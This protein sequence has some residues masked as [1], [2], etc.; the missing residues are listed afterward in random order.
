MRRIM[1][2][3]I[4]M[5]A[6]LAASPAVAAEPPGVLLTYESSVVPLDAGYHVTVL[7]NSTADPGEAQHVAVGT[8]VG[9][10]LNGVFSSR[11][12]PGSEAVT[13]VS[14]TAAGPF[15]LCLWGEAAF[16]AALDRKVLY[17]SAGPRCELVP[18]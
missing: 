18:L 10:T 9:C 17:A 5:A 12:M 11:G 6:V 15:E 1:A 2:V 3:G 16:F 8:V 7:C 13:V 4:S 14:A